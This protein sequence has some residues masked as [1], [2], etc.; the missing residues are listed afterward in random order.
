M[1]SYEKAV[2]GAGFLHREGVYY[3]QNLNNSGGL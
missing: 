2:K 3:W 1:A